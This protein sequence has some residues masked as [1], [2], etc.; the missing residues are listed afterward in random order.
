MRYLFAMLSSVTPS[1]IAGEAE[2]EQAL[3]GGDELAD[4]HAVR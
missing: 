2:F 3:P 4:R 1:T